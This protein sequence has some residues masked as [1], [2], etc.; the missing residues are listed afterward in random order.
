MIA[1]AV[2]G[3]LVVAAP[4]VAVR[5]EGEARSKAVN[6]NTNAALASVAMLIDQQ[7]SLATEVARLRADVQ[8]LRLRYGRLYARS[9]EA[10]IGPSI[11]SDWRPQPVK[12][13]SWWHIWKGG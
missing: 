13:K 9:P 12:R 3:A 10:A 7:E 11:P 4:A 1:K 2:A 5:Q 6:D 8:V